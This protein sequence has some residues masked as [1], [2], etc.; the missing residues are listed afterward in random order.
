MWVMG[1]LCKAGWRVV[2]QEEREELGGGVDV[3]KH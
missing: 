1:R 2:W 3:P